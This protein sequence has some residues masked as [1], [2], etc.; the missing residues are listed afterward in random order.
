MSY[1]FKEHTEGDYS[2]GPQIEMLDDL[3][4]L[5]IENKK[6][7]SIGAYGGYPLFF[8]AQGGVEV[9][10]LDSSPHRIRANRFLRGLLRNGTFE[11]NVEALWL[12]INQEP[13]QFGTYFNES[14]QRLFENC[15]LYGSGLP[16]SE[17]QESY[18]EFR[19]WRSNLVFL[20]RQLM[21][22]PPHK[23]DLSVYYPHLGDK[24]TFEKVKEKV[25]QSRY[26]I[27]EDD[28]L[29][30][31]EV[32]GEKFDLIYGSSVRH[33]VL[34]F[35]FLDVGKTSDDFQKQFDRRLGEA[36]RQRLNTGGIFVD[37]LIGTESYKLVPVENQLYWDGKTQRKKSIAHE[38]TRVELTYTQF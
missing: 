28:L 10:A 37:V 3:K 27:I 26:R 9:I 16:E 11:D 32:R 1:I 2:I 23:E 24:E 22:F 34:N 35:G 31:L 13:S 17:A 36:V 20:R 38:E 4:D 12:E 29:N 15:H 21:D 25:I 14:T 19:N 6:V 8:L 7:L 18:E 33:W 5:N 30:F